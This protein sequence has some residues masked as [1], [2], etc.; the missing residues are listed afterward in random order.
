MPLE[1]KAGA[2]A[3]AVVAE[4][5]LILLCRFLLGALDRR[6]PHHIPHD[7]VNL[8]AV[9]QAQ[10]GVLRDLPVDGEVLPVPRVDT[11]DVL[12]GRLVVDNY[13]SSVFVAAQQ[14]Q[15]PG[16]APSIHVLSADRIDHFRCEHSLN[17]NR[18]EWLVA[19]LQV[20]SMQQGTTLRGKNL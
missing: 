19:V 11:L 20:V 16:Q 15:L 7:A 9:Q 1:V 6:L 14:V 17:E 8:N 12:R 18:R 5:V 13:A 2:D 3:H 4:A 10:K